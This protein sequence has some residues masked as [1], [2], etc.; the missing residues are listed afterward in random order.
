[1]TPRI[2][3]NFHTPAGIADPYSIYDEAR[4]VGNVVWN[5]AMQGWNVF[6]FDEVSSVLTDQGERFTMLSSELAYWMEAPN[7]ITTDGPY[8][9]RLRA[10][11]SPRFTRSAIAKWEQRVTEVVEQL[12]APLR[13]GSRSYDMIADF[14]MIP[15]VIVADMVG[16]P[17]DR[18]E[19]F[20]RWSH[21]IVSNLA[22][23]AE[24]EEVQAIMRRAS[25]EINEYVRQEMD[26]HRREQPDDLLTA[27]LNFTGEQAMSDEVIRSTI[28]LLVLA[29]YDTT[30][31]LMGNALVALESHP[32]QRREIAQNLDLL[33]AAI[34]EA[35]RWGGP[36]QYT[37]P[38]VTMEDTELAGVKIS[39]GQTVYVF[40]AA[41][42]RDPRRWEDPHRFDVHRESKSNVGFGWGPHLCLGAPLAR[43]ETRV[44][45]EHLLRVAPEY[46]LRDVDLG[47]SFFMRGPERGYIEVGANASI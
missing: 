3:I 31:K 35:M 26:R 44:A 37:S 14:T 7:L 19:D 46:S 29:G 33:P 21:E 13:E 15:T 23:G 25:V 39:K 45:I 4:S 12:L 17:P 2:D 43:L 30:A 41:A 9:R 40:L 1:M 47:N 16:V 8:Q 38:R 20:R 22:W 32:D 42:N 24:Q 5:D 27:M 36:V 34:E 11:L 6:G 28:V 10:A 18:Y